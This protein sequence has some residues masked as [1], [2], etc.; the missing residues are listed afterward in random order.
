[1]RAS[2]QN[3]GVVPVGPIAV[4]AVAYGPDG[5]AVAASRTWVD[6]LPGGESK[7]V[8]FTWPAP[9]PAEATSLEVMPVYDVPQAR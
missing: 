3:L 2:V 7:S 8:I 4:V 6:R 5:N 9:W 1:M